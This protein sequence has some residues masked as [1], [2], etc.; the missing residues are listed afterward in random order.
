MERLRASVSGRLFGADDRGRMTGDF[1]RRT[2]FRGIGTAAFALPAAAWLTGCSTTEIG[3]PGAGAPPDT[4]AKGRTQGFLSIGVANE[5]PYTQISTS[6]EVT[7]VEPDVVRAVLK[8]LGIDEIQGIVTP[9]EAMIPGL[10]A[11][12]WDIIA[13]GLFMKQSRCAE[14]RYSEPDIVSEESF[15]VLPGN[16]KAITTVASVL[17]D[18]ALRIAV[19]PGGFEEGILQTAKAPDEQLVRVNDGRSGVE[20]LRAGR[21]DAFLLPT[22]SLRSL[23]EQDPGFDVTDPIADAPRTG[24]GAAFRPGDEALHSAYNTEL[25]ALKQTDE[26]GTILQKWGFDPAA[27]EGV[28]TEELC[29]NPG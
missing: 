29:R 4:L 20:A 8:R 18:P 9:Y 10:Q 25:A 5:P 23:Q 12:R 17:A 28:T 16:P 27:V 3:G 15:A 22:L 11:N 21:A 1:P 19:L 14:V 13:A 24:S 26:F 2:L 7:G 6:G